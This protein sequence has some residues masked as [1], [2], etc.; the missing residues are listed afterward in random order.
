M[1]N[2]D[3]FAVGDRGLDGFDLE[4][5]EMDY[6]FEL[7]GIM[8]MD[9]LRAAGAVINLGRLTIDFHE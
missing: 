3:R 9:L 7:G 6:G 1:R 4:I 8:G 5:G 2:V